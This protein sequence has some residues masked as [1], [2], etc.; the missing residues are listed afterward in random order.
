MQFIISLSLVDAIFWSVASAPSSIVFKAWWHNSIWI[1]S[2]LRNLVQAIL[3]S[4]LYIGGTWH[5]FSRLNIFV[6]LLSTAK[7]ILKYFLEI[8]H[9]RF[10][11]PI[12]TLPFTSIQQFDINI[13]HR[14]QHHSKNYKQINNITI[15]NFCPSAQRYM[16][17]Y[18][19]IV[20]IL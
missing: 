18:I 9:D 10:L 3:V 11:P 12:Y 20:H 14:A 19:S 15:R 1:T 6:I 13:L 16:V 5:S 2:W 17:Q 7:Q 4:D 8:G